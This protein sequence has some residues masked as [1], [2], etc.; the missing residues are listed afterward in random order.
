MDEIDLSKLPADTYV[1][2]EQLGN[3]KVCGI[4]DDLRYG[5]CF[6][7]AD[8]VMSDGEQAWDVRKPEIKWNVKPN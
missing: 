1:C 4:Y 5:S 7:C 3:C 6:K 8:Y 2:V